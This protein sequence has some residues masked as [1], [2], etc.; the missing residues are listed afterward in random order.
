MSS[1]M[2]KHSLQAGGK[3]IEKIQ[4]I[5]GEPYRPELDAYDKATELGVYDLW[6]LQR[7]RTALSKMYL[8]RWSNCEGLDAI[9]SPTTPYAAPKHGE[10]RHVG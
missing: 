4:D 10:F 2:I 9:L 8:D 3:S 5:S 7:E 6:Q 1:K